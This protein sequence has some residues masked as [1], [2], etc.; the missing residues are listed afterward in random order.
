MLM[1][2]RGWGKK[3]GFGCLRCVVFSDFRFIVIRHNV[4]PNHPRNL[5]C[6]DFSFQIEDEPARGK[7]HMGVR[8]T[9]K[10]KDVKFPFGEEKGDSCIP[11]QWFTFHNT[12]LCPVN[13]THRDRLT[14]V[15]CSHTRP[16]KSQWIPQYLNTSGALY[17]TGCGQV[18]LSAAGNNHPLNLSQNQ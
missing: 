3:M 4:P 11:R 7:F 17:F 10:V 6:A 1:V 5:F 13:H 16:R 15:I 2:L 8:K 18:T 12:S 14:E 9:L